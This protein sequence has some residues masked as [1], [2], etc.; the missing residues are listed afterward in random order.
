MAE[1]LAKAAGTKKPKRR[2]AAP[3]PAEGEGDED[4]D[5]EDVPARRKSVLA[6][7][8]AT[9][10]RVQQLLAKVAEKA[11]EAQLGGVGPV[12]ILR[13]DQVEE[14]VGGLGG[15]FR[16]AMGVEDLALVVSEDDLTLKVRFGFARAQADGR[17][18]IKQL[19]G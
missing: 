7:V 19:E 1:Q 15:A 17:G 3:P 14:M 9:L 10:S 6:E 18:T 16:V 4:D 2:P 12:P 13:Q 11:L 5:E 8:R